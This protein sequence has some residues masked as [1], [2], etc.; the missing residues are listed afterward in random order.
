M[1]SVTEMAFVSAQ[2]PKDLLERLTQIAKE[3]DRP[4][5]S[6]IREAIRD[7]VTAAEMKKAS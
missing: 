6:E 3:N 1:A 5:S 4:R 2:V 7:H